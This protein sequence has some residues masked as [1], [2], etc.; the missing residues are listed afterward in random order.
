MATV[1]STGYQIWI[2]LKVCARIHSV[3]EW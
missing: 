1:R 2:W 3:S